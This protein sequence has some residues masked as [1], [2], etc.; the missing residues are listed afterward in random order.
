MALIEAKRAA[1]RAGRDEGAGRVADYA[2][3]Y[4]RAGVPA[5]RAIATASLLVQGL[6]AEAVRVLLLQLPDA[7][8]DARRASDLAVV[9]PPADGRQSAPPRSVGGAPG[10]ERDGVGR[11]ADRLQPLSFPRNGSGATT[12]PPVDGA[13]D[14]A[15][16]SL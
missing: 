7:R 5:E 2:L 15:E 8:L 9:R 6:P 3:D 14:A 10:A 1:W 4:M 12:Y 13:P 11:T 16:V